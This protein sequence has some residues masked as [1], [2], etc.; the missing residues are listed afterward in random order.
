MCKRRKK[1]E[2]YGDVVYGESRRDGPKNAMRKGEG[3]AQKACHVNR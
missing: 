2:R 3:G 1:G